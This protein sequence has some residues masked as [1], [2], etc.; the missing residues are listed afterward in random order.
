MNMLKNNENKF[1][2]NHVGDFEISSIEKSQ[3]HYS[4]YPKPSL[5]SHKKQVDIFEKLEKEFTFLDAKSLKNE[6]HFQNAFKT[7]I[8]RWYP[9]REGYS[10]KLVNTFINRLD[11]KGLVFDP[12]SGSGTTMLSARNN[13]LKSYGI[14]VNP[15][16]VLVSRSENEIY[17]KSDIIEIEKTITNIK[18]INKSKLI[19]TTPFNLAEKTFNNEILQSLLQLKENLANI[20]N[21][22][23]RNLAFVSWL[24]IIES[25]SNFKKEGNGIK[26]KNRKRTTNGYIN[27]PK[28][29]WEK[30]VFPLDKFNFVKDKLLEKLQMMLY[31]IKNNYGSIDEKPII[32]ENNC[33]LFDNLFDEDIEFT[34]FSP[35][36]CNSFDYFEIHKVE[37][38][39]GDFI[40]SKAQMRILK[41]KGFRSNMNSLNNKYI[42]YKNDDLETLIHL[43]DPNKLWSKRIPDVVRGYF[44]DFNTLLKK[45]FKQTADS[46][47]VGIVVGNSAYSSVI[48]PTDVI[49][50][51]IAKEVGF[52]VENIY[53]TRH[54][55]TSSQQKKDL[56]PLKNYLR[57][58]IILL[59]KRK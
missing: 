57:E 49:V 34:F 8:Q 35:P 33:L 48:I 39:L 36:Y 32:I 17:I 38:W 11:V 53:I 12:F 1:S 4:F 44:D 55:T 9:Y 56:D 18:H 51:N 5:N 37:L 26:Y 21:E 27:I 23:I 15:I 45:L 52:V 13:N 28:E 54:L 10:Q 25:V 31:D 47:H 41:N 42:N 7:P 29:I 20:E 22:K 43:F 2:N 3:F 24:S 59:K 14:D 16:S 6:V 58:S 50:A 46:G 40:N 19:Y 30:Q